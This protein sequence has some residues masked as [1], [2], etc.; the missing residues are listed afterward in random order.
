MYTYAWLLESN[1]PLPTLVP[2]SN[3]PHPP[4]MWAC[5]A[6]LPA[7]QC[8]PAPSICRRVY[9]NSCLPHPA[10]WLWICYGFFLAPPDPLSSLCCPLP[11]EGAGETHGRDFI[12]GA[13]LLWG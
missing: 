12:N 13:H 10:A 4:L 3:L 2:P 7:A 8:P 6:R 5:P 1:P 11:S 9:I